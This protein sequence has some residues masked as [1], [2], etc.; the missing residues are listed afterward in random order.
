MLHNPKGWT[1]KQMLS[2]SLAEGLDL[3]G[4][5]MDVMFLLENVDVI[6]NVRDIK[7]PVKNTTLLME[8][9]NDHPGFVRLRL[10]S[11]CYGPD[12]LLTLEYF[13][14]SRNSIYLSVNKFLSNINQISCMVES[15]KTRSLF[16]RSR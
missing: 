5:D 11:A 8:T 13:E 3:P 10:I 7:H 1:M 9:D 4:S 2:G 14:T 12:Q 15:F 16:I 6:Q